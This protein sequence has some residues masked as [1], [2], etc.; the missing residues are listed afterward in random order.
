[1]EEQ[2]AGLLDKCDLDNAL[3]HY[4]FNNDRYHLEEE[5]DMH[6]IIDSM[7][8]TSIV[9]EYMYHFQAYAGISFFNFFDDKGF[10][11]R[12]FGNTDKKEIYYGYEYYEDYYTSVRCINSILFDI[13]FLFL[14]VKKYFVVENRKKK[15]FK[16]RK[17]DEEGINI[18]NKRFLLYII[19]LLGFCGLLD[20]LNSI[21]YSNYFHYNSRNQ[22]TFFNNIRNLFFISIIFV[23]EN[24]F[25]NKANYKHHYLGYFLCFISLILMIIKYSFKNIKSDISVFFIYFECGFLL[26]S[27]ILIE[28]KINFNYYIDIY[29]ICTIEGIIGGIFAFL[30]IYLIKDPI[31]LYIKTMFN[32]FD[33]KYI[34]VISFDCLITLF[35]N[36]SRLKIIEKNRP[37]YNSIA[38]ILANFLICIYEYFYKNKKDNIIHYILSLLFAIFGCFIFA[39]VIVLHFCNLDK[40][41]FDITYKRGINE[42][43]QMNKDIENEK[44]ESVIL[45]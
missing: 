42:M 22:I 23:S 8:D 38:N 18:F 15:I 20:L 21:D 6:P 33:I 11:V 29:F 10:Y 12:I 32:K 14:M 43:K 7:G 31:Y 9:S 34:I 13:L 2:R 4:L 1:M 36:I 45:N 27:E 28:K 37:S 35:Y 25:L 30:Y 17:N 26:S 39:E 44:E 5:T 19:I 24:I 3:I 41:T 16:I 40:Y